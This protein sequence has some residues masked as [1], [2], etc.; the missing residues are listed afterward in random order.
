MPL[1]TPSKPEQTEE[2]VA[3]LGPMVVHHVASVDPREVVR[4]LD[5]PGVTLKNSPKSLTRRVGSWVVKEHTPRIPLKLALLRHRYH[6]P[7][8]AA[9]R[10]HACGA[11]APAPIAFV[12]RRVLGV[13]RSTAMI[14][15]YLEG[16]TTVEQHAD[17]MAR[18]GAS[19]QE[20]LHYLAGLAEAV[21]RMERCGACHR[22]LAGKNILTLGGNDF[23]FIDLDSV[24]LDRTYS[25]RLRFKNHVQ[26]YDSFCDW[27][28]ASLLDPF[29][30]LMAPP[31]HDSV[32]WVDRVHRGQQRRRR[33]QRQRA[34][35]GV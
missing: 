17:T 20:V 13:P 7:W 27:W 29:L 21:N 30:L 14:M 12:E 19:G 15:E 11:G 8:R 25:A 23:R 9:L 16:Y 26:L 18:A 4:C 24:S 22:D 31:G 1:K 6:A 10:L 35:R 32:A 5:E 2:R 3:C 28:D 34:A 33:L